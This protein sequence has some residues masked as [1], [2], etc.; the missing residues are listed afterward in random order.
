MSQDLRVQITKEKMPK[1]TGEVMM[2]EAAG[3]DLAILIV[4]SPFYALWRLYR[5]LVLGERNRYTVKVVAVFE[6][7][8][9]DEKVIYEESL[10]SLREAKRRRT[11]LAKQ[12]RE[13]KRTFS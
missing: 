7:A 4:L 12:I 8:F 10:E 13:G 3:M 9:E 6:D 2:D 11:Q 5:R 1:G